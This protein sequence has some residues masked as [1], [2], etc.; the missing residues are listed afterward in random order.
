MSTVK[1]LAENKVI[2]ENKLYFAD[3]EKCSDLQKTKIRVACRHF[4]L[5]FPL[6]NK[7]VQEHTETGENSEFSKVLEN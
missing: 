5:K 4:A 6:Q 2:V 3:E 7:D 1:R